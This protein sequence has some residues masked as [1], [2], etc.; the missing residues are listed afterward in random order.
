MPRSGWFRRQQSTDRS[1]GATAAK[2]TAGGAALVLIAG[3]SIVA[4]DAP[5]SH[6][7]PVP[8][9]PLMRPFWTLG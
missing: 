9:V 2:L 4:L 5:G 1:R 6:A 7:A 3:I 8:S